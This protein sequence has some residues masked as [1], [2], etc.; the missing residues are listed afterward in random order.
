MPQISI[1]DSWF[2]LLLGVFAMDLRFNEIQS[3]YTWKLNRCL[4]NLR[5]SFW[6]RYGR[7]I[8]SDG[9]DPMKSRFSAGRKFMAERKLPIGQTQVLTCA[10]FQVIEARP[11]GLVQKKKTHW[12]GVGG[13]AV[14]A[15][16]GGAGFEFPCTSPHTTLIPCSKFTIN[17][18]RTLLVRGDASRRE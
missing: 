5:Q 1:L 16:H 4:T 14:V 11:D 18:A 10:G 6:S 12:A 8:A 3:G 17:K 13:Q 7:V 15:I 9:C 2:I